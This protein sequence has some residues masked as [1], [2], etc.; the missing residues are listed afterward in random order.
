[1]EQD[2]RRSGDALGLPGTLTEDL[3]PWDSAPHP[4]AEL[5]KGLQRTGW[6]GSSSERLRQ[7]LR[8][9]GCS[10]ERDF[11]SA[12]PGAQGAR[13]TAQ[14]KDPASPRDRHRPGGHRTA[15][16]LLPRGG[17]ELCR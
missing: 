5:P 8:G 16:T 10:R 7:M 2:P 17:P 14:A 12:G 15:R 4:A 9:G 3:R 1:M 11:N 13:D 6:T